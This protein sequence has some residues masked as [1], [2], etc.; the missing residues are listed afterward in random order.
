[1]AAH[2]KKSTVVLPP[3]LDFKAIPGG[4]EGMWI[5]VAPDRRILGKGYTPEEAMRDAN[6]SPED[7]LET[8]LARVP[9]DTCSLVL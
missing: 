5:V 9:P 4:L 2:A 3:S 1:M 6:L 7:A 8:F